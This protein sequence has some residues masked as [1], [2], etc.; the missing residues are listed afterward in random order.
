MLGILLMSI[1]FQVDPAWANTESW[2]RECV[3]VIQDGGLCSATP[4]VTGD[5]V[6]I[7]FDY[8]ADGVVDFQM[9]ASGL[10]VPRVANPCMTFGD[11]DTTDTD[12]N[13]QICLN[14]TTTSTG[15]EDCDITIAVQIAGVMTTVVT[16]DADSGNTHKNMVNLATF[17]RGNPGNSNDV[18]Q[19]M[20]SHSGGTI[21][22][23]PPAI[24]REIWCHMSNGTDCSG[25]AGA[26]DGCT[27]VTHGNCAGTDT[28]VCYVVELYL[29]ETDQGVANCE[30]PSE[31]E[32][33]CS[34][35]GL[36]VATNNSTPINLRVTDDAAGVDDFD[37]MYCTVWGEL[38]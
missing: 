8:D 17:E 13:G 18:K 34:V 35:T 5:G 26:N 15:A 31:A 22:S 4:A 27:P 37:E 33:K 23:T 1:Y 38:Q 11:S 10:T 32:S 19:V 12:D 21:W 36:S 28:D 3:L 2:I 20:A 24:I 16:Y 7:D 29:G 9:S 14:C 30:T 25:S 6:T